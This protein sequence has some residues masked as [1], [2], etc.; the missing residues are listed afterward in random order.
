MQQQMKELPSEPNVPQML[1]SSSDLSPLAT[2]FL[3]VP[4][5][6]LNLALSRLHLMT[7]DKKDRAYP[8]LPTAQQDSA[9]C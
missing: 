9:A 6:F 8:P 1:I 5:T 3:T 4:L 2:L 7:Q